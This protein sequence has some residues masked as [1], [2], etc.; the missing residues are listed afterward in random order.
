MVKWQKG[1]P[2][3]NKSD[4]FS[5]LYSKYSCSCTVWFERNYP[6]GKGHIR[7]H[8]VGRYN[9]RY[10]VKANANTVPQPNSKG[11]V[12]L[13]VLILL[14][15]ARKGNLSNHQLFRG[16]ELLGAFLSQT[17][18]NRIGG[19]EMKKL[20]HHSKRVMINIQY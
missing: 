12:T 7:V 5:K 13:N 16:L 3:P 14:Y 10:R 20:K 1:Q 11:Q 19:S 8:L 4:F 9:I 2:S 15:W 6:K 18:N 17:T